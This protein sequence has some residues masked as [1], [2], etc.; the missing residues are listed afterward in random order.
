MLW[1]QNA[2]YVSY[3]WAEQGT[4]SGYAVNERSNEQHF[5]DD[6]NK[7]VLMMTAKAAKLNPK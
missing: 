3:S 2:T 4:L 5:V 7:I 6:G 1:W